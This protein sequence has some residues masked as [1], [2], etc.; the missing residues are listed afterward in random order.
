MN[1]SQQPF[2]DIEATNRTP[3]GDNLKAPK[4]RL[5]T[6]PAR[7]AGSTDQMKPRR[8]E[9]PCYSCDEISTS[10]HAIALLL[11]TLAK[12]FVWGA[13]SAPKSASRQT[14]LLRKVHTRRIEAGAHPKSLTSHPNRKSGRPILPR[15]WV[16]W[17]ATNASPVLAFVLSV[18]E[19]PAGPAK[20]P[21]CLELPSP[22]A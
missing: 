1:R 11:H 13:P 6:S 7:R 2:P 14:L 17:A 3:K 15:F 16:G 19:K 10:L 4:A 21:R 20:G 22:Q 9:S 18:P 12:K 5:D 8:A